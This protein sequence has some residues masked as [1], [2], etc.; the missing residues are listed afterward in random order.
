MMKINRDEHMVYHNTVIKNIVFDVGQVLLEFNWRG[1]IDSMK[2]T[3]D[4]KKKLIN[5]TLGNMLHWNEHDRGMGDEEFIEKSLLL[6]PDIGHEIEYYMKNIG[7]IVKEY[8]Y[9][10]PLIKELKSKGYMVYILS[11][12]GATPFKYAREHMKFFDE[13][14]GMVISHEVGCIK[15][16]PEIY[17]ILF[18]RFNLVP[19]ECVFIDDRPDNIEAAEKQGM[20]G[21]VFDNIENVVEKLSFM[22]GQEIIYDNHMG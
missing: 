21:I 11:N 2:L 10:V 9:S 6:E 17:Q 12:Y 7:T 8:S 13:V 20:K 14:D 19:G 22:L 15:P 1:F 16:E 3:E 5:V 4:K 18:D